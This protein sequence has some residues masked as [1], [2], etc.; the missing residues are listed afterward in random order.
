MKHHDDFNDDEK[1]EIVVDCTEN[2][3]GPKA[4]S[5]KHNT[6]VYVIRCFVRAKGLLTTPDDLSL[7]PG[8]PKKSENMTMNDYQREIKKFWNVKKQKEKNEKVKKALEENY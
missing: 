7:Y 3:I 4:L 1:K 6:M 2:L 5:E 8:Y